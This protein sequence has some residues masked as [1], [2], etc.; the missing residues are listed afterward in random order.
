MFAK[1]FLF[2][3]IMRFNREGWFY[4]ISH[5]LCS[6]ILFSDK[7]KYLHFTLPLYYTQRK[8]NKSYFLLLIDQY[9]FS[10]FHVL[11]YIKNCF[12]GYYK[13]WNLFLTEIRA[14]KITLYLDAYLI[15]IHI[16]LAWVAKAFL[17]SYK[18]FT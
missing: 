11:N 10:E 7:Y 8:L 15:F 9:F 3:K 2:L 17:I 14:I 12:L 18:I 6:N 4:S 16:S 13:N 1:V 5:T